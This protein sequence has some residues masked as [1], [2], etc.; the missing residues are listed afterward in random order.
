MFLILGMGWG[1]VFAVVK[2]MR[3]DFTAMAE[4]FDGFTKRLPETHEG[5]VNAPPVR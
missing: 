2:A 3:R 1:E 5:L 4:R